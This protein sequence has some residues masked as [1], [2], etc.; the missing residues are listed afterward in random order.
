MRYW[1][2]AISW[3]NKVVRWV[4]EVRPVFVGLGLR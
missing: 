1:A 2:N 3:D 4:D